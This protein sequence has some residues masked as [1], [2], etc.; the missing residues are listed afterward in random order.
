MVL[1]NRDSSGNILAPLNNN[2]CC[3]LNSSIFHNLLLFN[4]DRTGVLKISKG[5][6][7]KLMISILSLEVCLDKF[8]K[9]MKFEDGQESWVERAEQ[10]VNFQMR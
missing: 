6:A 1:C 10:D 9:N 2:L 5:S 3:R 7:L 8:A 4:I